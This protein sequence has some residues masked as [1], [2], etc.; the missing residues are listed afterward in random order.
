MKQK[1]RKIQMN[2]DM[3][4]S[5]IKDLELDRELSPMQKEVTIEILDNMKQVRSSIKSIERVKE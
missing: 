1:L 5:L 2:I 3:A 4:I